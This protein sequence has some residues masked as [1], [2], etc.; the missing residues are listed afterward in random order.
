MSTPPTSSPPK[1]P[2][3]AALP[4]KYGVRVLTSIGNQESLRALLAFSDLH[5][6]L[7]SREPVASSLDPELLRTER[8][9]LIEVLQLL[10]R[11]ALALTRAD[12]ILIALAE[13][14]E[15]VCCAVAG[16][17][18]IPP[19]TRLNR[20]S[21]FLREC[22]GSGQILRCGDSHADARFEPYVARQL[23]FRSTVIVPLRG[24]NQ[25]VGLLQVFAATPHH[26]SENDVRCLDLLAEL[27]LA[28]LKPGDQDRRFHW[29]SGVASEVLQRPNSVAA[30]PIPPAVIATEPVPDLMAEVAASSTV[31]VE[32]AP[33]AATETAANSFVAA[34]PVSDVTAEVA[35]NSSVAA[36][37]VHEASAQ[38]VAEEI[39]DWERPGRARVPLVPKVAQNQSRLP[40][41]EGMPARESTFSAASEGAA[42]LS[43]SAEPHEI[44]TPAVASDSPSPMAKTV[45][46]ET[47]SVAQAQAESAEP[48]PI[49]AAAIE[50]ESVE[51]SAQPEVAPPEMLATPLLEKSAAP[52]SIETNASPTPEAQEL[53]PSDLLA[54]NTELANNDDEYPELFAP[55]DLTL[56][57]EH[58]PFLASES[59]EPNQG[60]AHKTLFHLAARPGLALVSG[61]LIVV[62]LF[63]AGA[64]WGMQEH[65]SASS[66][67]ASNAKSSRGASPLIPSSPNANSDPSLT[68]DILL[69]PVPPDKLASLP[70]I[71]GL[72]HWSS[73]EGS[74]VVI[75]MEDQVNYEVHR[76]VSPDRIYFDL[77]DTS[78]PRDLQAKSVDV[79]DPSLSRVRIAQPV[80]GVTRVVLDTRD[81]ANFSVSMESDPY[82][83]VVDLRQGPKSQVADRRN[84]SAAPGATASAP[85]S[86]TTNQPPLPARSGRFR[87]VLDAGHGG[88]DL[89][90]IGRQGLVEKDLVL[91]VTRRLAKLLESRNGVEVL[92]TRSGDDYIPLDERAFIANQSQADLFVSVHA[93]HSSSTTA[94]GVETYYTNL[95]S[96]PGLKE[97]EKHPDGTFSQN[98]PVTLSADGLHDKIEESRRLA[99]SVQRSLYAALAAKSPD[100]RDR[101]IKD[102]SFVVLTGT[103]MPSILTEISFVSSPAD[104]HNL[105]SN[106]YREQIAEALY[107][108]I[109]RYQETTSK[110]KLAQLHP[111]AAA[112]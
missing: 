60:W 77:H 111:I 83:L 68:E 39:D 67:R 29:L 66:T 75:D 93:N 19:G 34:E 94:R 110:S 10:C 30:E 98:P 102:A 57:P 16:P 103:T 49:E 107:K 13:G 112:H 56:E 55:L 24:G 108:G 99:T 2:G 33:K 97:V 7:L 1:A 36:E 21:A 62:A 79:G 82:R 27:V 50:T 104:E 48:T 73:A 69:T 40:A 18:P 80:A 23:P 35:P 52:I 47:E 11:R 51:P 25:R 28:A 59:S 45:E 38:M 84:S 89:G 44:D 22:L 96:A 41:A 8:L 109:A 92:F 87:I 6:N 86:A 70:K 53:A 3:L 31:A 46:P 106:E 71:T 78:L 63:S 42:N 91:D 43:V 65:R 85:L 5:E 88:W 26:F 105:Q 76:L 12:S 4:R 101:G 72:R 20:D 15:F 17:S 58:L 74:T 9:I 61:L 95:F 64:W 100:I 81:G 14:K 32:P 37:S 90:T 54:N